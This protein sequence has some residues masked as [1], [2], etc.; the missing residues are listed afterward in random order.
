MSGFFSV[1]LLHERKGESILEMEYDGRWTEIAFL[2]RE[3]SIPI[4]PFFFNK[5]VMFPVM[6]V[7]RYLV[8]PQEKWVCVHETKSLDCD[9]Q[10][11]PIPPP[12]GT[13]VEVLHVRLLT[14]I[15]WSSSC[16][17][18]LRLTHQSLMHGLPTDSLLRLRNMSSRENQSQRRSS[19]ILYLNRT[20]RPRNVPGNRIL[21][22][23]QSI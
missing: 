2:S 15:H 6:V 19:F 13:P 11:P 3:A 4:L 10:T 17:P 1:T 8:G 20:I 16:K 14:Q 22:G 21:V 12:L 7:F 18:L 23:M 9:G 5:K